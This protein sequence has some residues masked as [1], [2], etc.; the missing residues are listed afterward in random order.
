MKPRRKTP[1][2]WK[3]L[4]HDWRRL[5]VA[6]CG[7]AF[8]VLLM[9]TQ[10]GFQ[11]ALFDSQVKLIDDLEGDIFLISKAK[12]TLAS[13]K[14]FPITRLNQARACAGVEGAY[15]VY[16]ELT[17]SVLRR[18]QNGMGN[19]GFPLRSI[20]FYLDD[21]VFDSAA[22]NH[23][24]T[25]LRSQGTALIDAKSKRSKFPFPYDDDDALAQEQVELA[26]KNL[27]LVGTFELGTDFAHDGNLVMSAENFAEFFP[28]RVRS[29][30]P[31][32]VIDIGIVDVLPDANVD[33]VRSLIERSI[34]KDVQVLTREEYREAEIHFWDT[35]TPIGTIFMAGKIIGFIVGM[36]ICYQVIYSDIADHMAEFA[37]LKAMGYTARYFILLILTEAVLLA[38]VGFVPGCAVS[39]VMYTWLSNQTGLLMVMSRNTIMLVFLL[40]VAMCVASGLLA[41]RKLL[42][43]D[44]ASLF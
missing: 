19:R 20:G 37:T 36:V 14:R 44:P 27:T 39:T 12:F 22:I 2:A 32:S 43:A 16:T 4:T 26:S 29:G 24:L 6:I 5:V 7:I 34:D 23:Q 8:A 21:P 1:L 42:S 13:E 25:R 9:F 11:N 31:L 10:V 35:S 28:Q 18:M 17:T 38:I 41:V 30:D 40:T 33:E 15:P 3:N